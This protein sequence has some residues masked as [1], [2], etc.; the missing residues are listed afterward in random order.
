MR[1]HVRIVVCPYRSLVIILLSHWHLLHHL[2][3]ILDLDVQVV[4]VEVHLDGHWIMVDLLRQ[5]DL[6][7]LLLL[8]RGGTGLNDLRNLDEP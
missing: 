4:P 8:L 2:V 5:V 3:D 6:L 7:L 1:G